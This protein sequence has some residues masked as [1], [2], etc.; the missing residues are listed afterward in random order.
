MK[1][2]LAV[3]AALLGI[4]AVAVLTIAVAMR[5]QIAPAL[6]VIRT[7][8]R[9]VTN[10]ALMRTA[11]TAAS[12]TAVVVHVGRGSG[13][14]YRT[15]VHI[16]RFGDRI[17]IAL[18]YGRDVDWVRNITT[19]GGAVIESGGHKAITANPAIVAANEVSAW[20]PQRQRRAIALF[21]V[22]ECL[23]LDVVS[24]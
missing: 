9:T 11:G 16:D 15:P 5:W 19:H 13:R 1:R 24:E 8:N 10:P 18:P 17:V 2:L 23:C 6:R 12:E 20:L 14:T 22:R 7:L 21:G 4:A 3:P